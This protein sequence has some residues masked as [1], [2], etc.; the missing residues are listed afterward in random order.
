MIKEIDDANGNYATKDIKELILVFDSGLFVHLDQV[1]VYEESF[2]NGDYK[3][4]IG[5]ALLNHQIDIDEFTKMNLIGVDMLYD[6]MSP[7]KL[8]FVK[9]RKSYLCD[10]VMTD[11]KISQM[12]SDVEQLSMTFTGKILTKRRDEN[13]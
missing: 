2:Q 7:V 10:M 12:N 1:V 13:E 11:Y 6:E 5:L 4:Q 9:C 3:I 8:D